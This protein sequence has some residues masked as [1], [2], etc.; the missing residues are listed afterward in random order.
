MYHYR[1]ILVITYICS[2]PIE[3]FTSMSILCVDLI[4]SIDRTEINLS[5]IKD[6][7]SRILES[8]LYILSWLIYVAVSSYQVVYVLINDISYF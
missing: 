5:F 8:E 3:S 7:Q 1:N 2:I 4:L 6:V